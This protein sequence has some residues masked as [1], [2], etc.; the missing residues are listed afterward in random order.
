MSVQVA[1]PSEV[2]SNP[3]PTRRTQPLVSSTKLACSMPPPTRLHSASDA[4][5][6]AFDWE[7]ISPPV[8]N[9]ANSRF[10][11]PRAIHSRPAYV[12]CHE[13]P[14]SFAEP[15]ASQV[16]PLSFV[17]K[18]ANLGDSSFGSPNVTSIEPESLSA[19]SGSR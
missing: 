15:L 1:P 10:G 9:A 5:L 19:N 2:A 18:S 7:T 6:E 12:V 13:V 11:H 17:V 14:P 3:P 16:C 8:R 4:A